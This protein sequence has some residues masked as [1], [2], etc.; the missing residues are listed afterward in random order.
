[1]TS[2]WSRWSGQS[3]DLRRFMVAVA[4][5]GFSGAVFDA[6][7]NNFLADRFHLDGLQRT[8]LEI[9]REIPGL[10][11]AFVSALL[12]FLPSR[13]LA[14]LAGVVSA[15]G[16][17]LMSPLSTT[18][19][20]LWPWLF[21]YSLGQHLFMPVSQSVGMELSRQGEPAKRLGQMNSLRHA[22]G[23][24]GAM[25]VWGL[26]QLLP[27]G[28]G[29][30]LCLAAVA[31]LAG[32]WACLR[33]TRDHPQPKSAHLRLHREYRLYY[34]LAVLFGTRKQIFLTFAPWVLVSVFGKETSSIARLLALGAVLGVVIQPWVGR[35]IDAKGE[36]FALG[37]EAFLLLWVCLGYALARDVLPAGLAFPLVAACFLADQ[38]LMSFNMAR[39]T[40]LRRIAL[41]PAHVTPTLTMG[42]TIDHVFS[43]SI[44][45]LGGALWKAFGYQAVFLA[46]AALSVLNGLAAWRIPKA[47]T[48]A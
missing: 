21:L 22:A 1:M 23:I 15:L 3:S 7:F 20:R 30:A 29:A 33:M 11:V 40:F 28:F 31:A 5:F 17:A 41:E 43:I 26:F 14:A 47:A 46:G 12:A 48:A 44:A 8:L 24:A 16:L 25:C 34:T 39:S 2:W 9:P 35:M 4:T 19:F 37:L 42:V 18:Y 27:T 38:I 45:L 13:R 10:S 6:V 32:G 36:R